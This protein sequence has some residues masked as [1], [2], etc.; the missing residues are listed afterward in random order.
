MTNE[1]W[2][3]LAEVARPHGVR[4]ELRLRLFNAESDLLLEPSDILVRFPDGREERRTIAHCRRAD[5]ALLMKFDDVNDRDAAEQLR[6]AHVCLPRS[7]FPT[8]DAGEFYAVDVIGADVLYLGRR[9]GSVKD[10]LTYPS[11]EVLVVAADDG[12]GDW[13]VPLTD[14]FVKGVDVG[15]RVVELQTLDDLERQPMR[16]KAQKVQ[17]ATSGDGGSV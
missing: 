12:E 13:E 3:P 9:I 7:Q 11:V 15:E 10:L 6:G 16:K 1:V 14:M 8:V 4:G 2:I 17:S 5:Q